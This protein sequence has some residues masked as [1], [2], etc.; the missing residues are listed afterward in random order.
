MKALARR[1]TLGC[2]ILAAFAGSAMGDPVLDINATSLTSYLPAAAT[3]GQDVL[4]LY[5][6]RGA[7]IDGTMWAGSTFG[8]SLAANPMGESWN[9]NARMTGV[10]LDTGTPSIMDVDLSLPSAGPRWTI[11][12]TYNA[13]QTTA[14]SPGGTHRDS[15]GY[16]GR[17][18][19][20]TSQPE[21]QYY[22]SGSNGPGS[23]DAVYIVYGA[24]RYIEFKWASTSLNDAN[25]RK[26]EFRS[27]NG[28]AG[29][30]QFVHDKRASDPPNEVPDPDLWTYTDQMGTKTTFFG[31]DALSAGAEWQVWKIVDEAGNTAFV[32]GTTPYAGV[33]PSCTRPTARTPTTAALR[34]R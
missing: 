23:G 1:F 7:G 33:A 26:D 30:V 6:Q 14:G 17:N 5:T 20:Q 10:H 22:D 25:T 11:G 28:A 15:N 29:V 19:F 2:G 3:A 27:E 12:R 8:W 24:D 31:G 13:V 16:Q 9:G 32:G 21:I 18:W 4:P 34:A